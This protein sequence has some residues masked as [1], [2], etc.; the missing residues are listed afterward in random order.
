MIGVLQEQLAAKEA[1]WSQERPQMKGMLEAALRGG[2]GEGG[3]GSAVAGGGLDV[4]AAIERD[5]NRLLANPRQKAIE[6]ILA[7]ARADC[8]VA[9]RCTCTP[10][11]ATCS[12][13][14]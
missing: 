12:D 13:S 7:T 11:R 1:S 5:K 2:D 14:M 8:V 9:S 10:K 3:G 4:S 6:S